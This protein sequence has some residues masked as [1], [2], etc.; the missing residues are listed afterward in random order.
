EVEVAGTRVG[1]PIRPVHHEQAAALNRDAGRRA[2]ALDRTLAE[3]RR[4]RPGL[5]AETDLHRADAAA[6]DRLA[7]EVAEGDVALLERHRVDVRQVVADDIERDGF[8]VESRE[9]RWK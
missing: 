3:L 1:L 7:D 5:H 4:D 9:T 8:R 6:A 2:A